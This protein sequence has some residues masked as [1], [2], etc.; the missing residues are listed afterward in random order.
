VAPDAVLWRHVVRNSL[1]PMLTIVSNLVP[2]L[3]VGS[4]VVESIF[5]IPGMGKLA[6]DAA[7]SKDRELLMGTTLIVSG[8]VLL[9][10][11]LRDLL[12]AAADP[13]VSYE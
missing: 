8:I 2:A 6:V 11:L 12:Y 9:S 1:L 4:V 5:S 7:F 10:E 13:R 3:L